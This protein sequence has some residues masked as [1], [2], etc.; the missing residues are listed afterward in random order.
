[1]GLITVENAEKI[2]QSQTGGY[3][4][5]QIPYELSLGRVLAESLFAD[6]DLPPFNRAAVDG[7]ALAYRA[8]AAG[9]RT[10]TI[11]AVQAAGEAPAAIPST[12]DCIEIMTGAAVDPSVDT[13][14]RYEDVEI[15]D[16][17]ATVKDVAIRKGQNVHP[18]GKDC[19]AGGTVADAGRLITPALIGVA[20]SIGK[21]DL[22]VQRLPKVIIITTG[23]EL[24]PVGDNPTPYQLRR[25]NDVTVQ[26]V[27]A[28]YGIHADKLHLKDDYEVLKSEFDRCLRLYDVLLLTGGVSM[29]KFDYIPQALEHLGVSKLFHKVKQRPGKPFW[30]GTY[31]NQQLVFAFPG[32]PVSVF[33]CLHRYFIPWLARSMGVQTPSPQ[34][35]VLQHDIDF[36]YPLQY[37]AQVKLETDH[38]GVLMAR[39]ANTNGS[40]DFSHLIHTN[41]FMELPLEKNTFKKG[42]VYRVWPYNV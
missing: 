23:D 27:L 6:R 8:Y 21:T 14:I 20:A 36:P 3:G 7:I 2:I 13:V 5:E 28:C 22:L 34:Y 11:N 25:S 33:M 32:N 41:A 4:T 37:F 26:S 1:M 38:H 40:G 42:E 24:V 10:F 31:Q 18:Q 35:A 30:F 17:R 12:N 19:Q 29:G 16:G 39:A 15:A 9:L